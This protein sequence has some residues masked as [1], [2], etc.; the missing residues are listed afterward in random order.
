MEPPLDRAPRDKD[1]SLPVYENR[2]TTTALDPE[3]T[4][5]RSRNNDSPLGS[6]FDN[7]RVTH[8]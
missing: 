3:L 6:H 4:P 7:V 1:D 5:N 8:T 2:Q